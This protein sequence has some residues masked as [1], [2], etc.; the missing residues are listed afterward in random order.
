M[1]HNDHEYELLW[2]LLM[3]GY[4]V[5]RRHDHHDHRDSTAIYFA[6]KSFIFPALRAGSAA[7]V[8]GWSGFSI[9]SGWVAHAIVSRAACRLSYARDQPPQPTL[10]DLDHRE[11]MLTT[12]WHLKG[13]LYL[14]MLANVELGLTGWRSKASSTLLLTGIRQIL[15]AQRFDTVTMT[16]WWRHGSP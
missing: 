10:G 5:P 14:C 16:I 15:Y 7:A 6:S 12:S 11:F 3:E 1:T 9:A 8:F 2:V 13:I 4:A